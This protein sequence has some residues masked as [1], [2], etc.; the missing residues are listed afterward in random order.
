MRG[1]QALPRGSRGLGVAGAAALAVAVAG[2]GGGERQDVNEKSGSYRV[3]VANATFPAKQSIAEPTEMRI[4]VRN[5][6]TKPLPDV[7]VTIETSAKGAA[8]G[9]PEAFASDIQDPSV[10]DRSR[11]IWVVDQ[12]PGGGDTAY[13][14]TWAL[15]PLKAGETRTFRWKVTA[16]KPGD[17]TVEYAVSPGLNGKAKAAGGAGT[18]SFKVSIDDSPPSARVG[19]DGEVIRSPDDGAN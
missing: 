15:G 4:E 18:G 17:Y 5:A 1:L 2:C 14:N 11:P 16:V 13:T 8:G 12:G 3:E 10:S 7:A 9:A 6:D 19:S